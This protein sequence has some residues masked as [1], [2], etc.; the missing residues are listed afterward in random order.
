[1]QI[2]SPLHPVCLAAP[3]QQRMALAHSKPTYIDKNLLTLTGDIIE[4]NPRQALRELAASLDWGAE[5]FHLA[6][7]TAYG[8]CVRRFS[9]TSRLRPK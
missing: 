6:L 7:A 1:M 8:M 4:D 3:L 5:R 9:F 2:S